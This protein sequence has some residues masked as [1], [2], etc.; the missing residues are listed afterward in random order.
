M[1]TTE[2]NSQFIDRRSNDRPEQAGLERRQ[3]ANSHENLS[4]DARELADAIDQ[5]KLQ[6]RRRFITCEEILEVV[7]SLGYSKAD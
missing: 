6:K 5:Y 7:H 3:F 4:S 1:A 2:P